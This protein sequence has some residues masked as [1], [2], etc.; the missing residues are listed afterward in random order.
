MSADS[1]PSNPFHERRQNDPKNESDWRSEYGRDKARIVH[2]AA[3]RRLQ[4]KTQVMG[5]GEGDFHRTRLTHSLEVAQIGLGLFEGLV[6]GKLAYIPDAL[7]P[8]LQEEGVR[9][10]VAASC[11][12]HDLGHPPFGH[13][14]E[15]ALHQEVIES[16]GFEGNAQTIRILTK[17]EK[18]HAK[19]IGINP[20]R[21]MLLAVLK[22]P[23]AYGDYPKEAAQ[24]EP[25]KCFY[26]CH[27]GD[28][29]WA[30]EGFDEPDRKE[31]T[32]IF[33][34]KSGKLKPKHMTFDASVMNCADDIAYCSHDLE[35]IV[36]RNIV[37]K[38]VLLGKLKSFF[39]SHGVITFN[40]FVI[41][42]QF[43]QSLYDDSYKRNGIIGRLVNSLMNSVTVSEYRELTHP[44]LRYRLEIGKDVSALTEYLKKEVTYR[45]V[46]GQPKLQML[47]RKGQHVISRIYKELLESPEQLIHS[48]QDFDPQ[49]RVERRVCDY[50]AGMTD[51]YAVKLYNRL[52]TP[53]V[54][55]TTD[56]L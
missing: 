21:R 35:D 56:E 43:F 44:L 23:A 52:F 46:V 12:A 31:C 30:L 8:F 16:G 4:G 24:R 48:W 13:G 55:T 27:A 25:Q 50:V 22:Y 49:D 5:V 11:Y 32:R 10:I 33:A 42:F 38:D 37:G 41:D 3:F 51:S 20:T 19:Y 1:R 54:G 36:A 9:D 14:G 15:R 28:I 2:G 18:Y 29:A 26:D 40:E 39:D 53:G 47:E 6:K 17:L 45:L 7:R 34:T